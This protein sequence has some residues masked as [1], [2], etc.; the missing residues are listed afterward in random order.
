MLGKMP[1]SF[2]I[3]GALLQLFFI[4]A[5]RFAYRFFLEEKKRMDRKK[6]NAMIIGHVDSTRYVINLLDSGLLGALLLSM[7]GEGQKQS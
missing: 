5:S 3:V 6:K 2:Y 4:T 1:I 7:A